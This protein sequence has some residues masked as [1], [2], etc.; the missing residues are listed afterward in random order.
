MKFY[1]I[2]VVNGNNVQILDINERNKRNGTLSVNANN[3]VILSFQKNQHEQVIGVYKHP[4]NIAPVSVGGMPYVFADE[5]KVLICPLE[6]EMEGVIEINSLI[7]GY[8]LITN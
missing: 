3:E 5:N 4:N 6:E 2:H 1:Q 7:E 8:Y